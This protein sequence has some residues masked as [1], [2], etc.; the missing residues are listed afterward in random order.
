[1]KGRRG[2]RGSQAG[3][4]AAG[5]GVAVV[6][7]DADVAVALHVLDRANG[8]HARWLWRLDPDKCRDAL[9]AARLILRLD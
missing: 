5:L 2:M 6:L 7:D 8:R 9:L 3:L 1:M 4:P